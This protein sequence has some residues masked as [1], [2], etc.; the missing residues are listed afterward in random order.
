MK[1][2]E[3]VQKEDKYL[4]VYFHKKTGDIKIVYPK[5]PKWAQSAALAIY[6]DT[7]SGVPTEKGVRDIVCGLWAKIIAEAANENRSRKRN[8]S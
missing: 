8:I 6:Y 3:R 4:K 1:N 5:A 2:W 7:K